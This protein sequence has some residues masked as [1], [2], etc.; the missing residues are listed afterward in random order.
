[1]RTS[2]LSYDQSPVS[3]IDFFVWICWGFHN[4]G[5]YSTSLY[6]SVD[7]FFYESVEAFINY[8]SVDT[9]IKYESVN[10]FIKETDKL[11]INTIMIGLLEDIHMF[12]TLFS[13]E[14]L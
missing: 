14:S 10:R 8:G 6:E 7:T 9:F 13:L 2:I 11:L 3:S 1:M 5:R 12:G 4:Y